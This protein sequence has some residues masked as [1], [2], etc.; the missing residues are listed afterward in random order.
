MF[1]TITRYFCSPNSG[2]TSTAQQQGSRTYTAIHTPTRYALKDLSATAKIYKQVKSALQCPRRNDKYASCS[3]VIKNVGAISKSSSEV[4]ISLPAVAQKL[5]SRDIQEDRFLLNAPVVFTFEG[6]ELEGRL[7]GVFDGHGDQ[8]EVGDLLNERLA[9]LLGDVLTEKFKSASSYSDNVNDAV[10]DAFIGTL[11]ILSA[12]VQKS[13]KWGGATVT[14]AF[15]FKE[16]WYCVNVG[17]SRAILVKPDQTHQLT[18]DAAV[19]SPRFQ[20][21][22]KKRNI[23]IWKGGWETRLLDPD[24]NVPTLN[25]ARDIGAREWICNRA[26][27]TTFC[28]GD[29]SD[30]LSAGKIYCKGGENFLVIA[31]DGLFD[32]AT[33]NE[34][35][36]AVRML[37]KAGAPPQ[38]I[39]HLIADQAASSRVS[40]NVTVMVIPI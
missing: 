2:D 24:F 16:R 12:E 34:V 13:R 15:S 8:G 30:D 14:C 5:G 39:A 40:D 22:Y 20:K 4:D 9:P 35:G 25:V 1:S 37:A 36:A 29:T 10:A 6:Q 28:M 26:K 27:I 38:Q 7:F 19:S 32:E 11:S 23:E 21:W 18:E 17:D 3:F 33:T 31:S